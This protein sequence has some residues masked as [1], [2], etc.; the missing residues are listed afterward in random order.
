MLRLLALI[1]ILLPALARAEAL[2]V[3]D[4]NDGFLNLRTG[5]GTDFGI[6]QRLTAGT[7]VEGVGASGTWRRVVLPDG[8]G[9]WASGTYLT[10]A[11]R[12][13]RAYDYAVRP[14][15]DGYL[16][17]RTGPGTDYGIV[18]RLYAGQRAFAAEWTGGWVRLAL[19]DGTRG[20]ASERYLDY[21][22]P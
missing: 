18:Q 3:V 7:G 20:W 22:P 16:N 10:R 8:R 2:Y 17:L 1:L 6:V 13:Q 21:I 14:T 5:P 12:Q 15:N 9:G 19:P 4:T 11:Y